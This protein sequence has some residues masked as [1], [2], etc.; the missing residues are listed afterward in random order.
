MEW[1]VCF[2][3]YN[4]K[5]RIPKII[6]DWGHTFWETWIRKYLWKDGKIAWPVCSHVTTIKS[7]K[8]LP[9]TN[10]NMISMI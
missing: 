7:N 1:E 8:D 5:T 9:I 10:Y 4:S 6:K 3:E 2:E